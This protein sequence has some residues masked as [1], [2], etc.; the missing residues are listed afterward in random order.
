[1]PRPSDKMRPPIR[2]VVFKS[3]RGSGAASPVSHP[4][5]RVLIPIMGGPWVRSDSSHRHRRRMDAISRRIDGSSPPP[6]TPEAPAASPALRET[7]FPPVIAECRAVLGTD[8]L[9]SDAPGLLPGAFLGGG[10]PNPP[11]GRPVFRARGP[12]SSPMDYHAYAVHEG[13]MRWNG[14][15][16]CLPSP[17][18]FSG[19]VVKRGLCP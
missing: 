5:N 16:A 3:K 13:S 1:M 4:N 19:N 6:P 2:R 8:L 10:V 7:V 12:L 18:I 11:A 9:P 14:G 15:S 17:A